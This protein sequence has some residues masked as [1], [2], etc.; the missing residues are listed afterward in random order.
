M[1]GSLYS[2]GMVGAG[3]HSQFVLGLLHQVSITKGNHRLQDLREVLWVL[4][5]EVLGGVRV[6]DDHQEVDA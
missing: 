1:C 3:Y 4:A 6:Q 5:H 2:R